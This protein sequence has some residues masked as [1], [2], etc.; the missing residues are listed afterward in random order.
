MI[1]VIIQI[2]H[3]FRQKFFFILC[4]KFIPL[5]I[6]IIICKIK[7]IH[8][9]ILVRA[10]EYR[11]SDIESQRFGRQGQ[12]DL[13]YLTDIHTRRH[14]QRI[15]YDIQRPSVRQE[16]HILHRQYTGNNTLIT[17][18]SRHL[19]SN[20]DLSLLRDIDAHRLIDSR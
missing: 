9:I 20:G 18:A 11:R 3:H 1:P 6:H 14:A 15:Q 19:I 12:M 5:Q 10:V 4:L 7:R 16:R 13:Q 17:V 8:D 2:L